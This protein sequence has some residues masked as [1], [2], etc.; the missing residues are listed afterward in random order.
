MVSTFST[1]SLWLAEYKVIYHYRFIRLLRVVVCW[2]EESD[3]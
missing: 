3:T 1:A 2:Q